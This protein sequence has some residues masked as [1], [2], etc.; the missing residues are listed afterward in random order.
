M[1]QIYL[2]CMCI[3]LMAA[4]MPVHT[5]DQ[6]DIEVYGGLYDYWMDATSIAVSEDVGYVTTHNGLAGVEFDRAQATLLGVNR[7]VWVTHLFINEDNIFALDPTS[8]M[9][10]LDRE[11]LEI[12]S[13]I[14]T[15]S[16]NQDIIVNRDIAYIANHMNG[17]ELIDISDPANPEMIA[18]LDLPGAS[19]KLAYFESIIY[20]A[21]AEAGLRIVDVS[22]P[23][24]PV[25]VGSY[26]LDGR[27][28]DVNIYGQYVLIA[29]D[30]NGVG[31]LDISD[32]ENV[33][34]IS[35]YQSEGEEPL[36]RIREGGDFVYA[37]HGENNIEILSVSDENEIS[38]TNLF[39]IDGWVVTNIVHDATNLYV[40]LSLPDVYGGR[41]ARIDMENPENVVVTSA[42]Q[43]VGEAQDVTIIGD[44]GFLKDANRHEDS[45]YRIFDVTN[46]ENPVHVS[47][48]AAIGGSDID[49]IDDYLFIASDAVTIY[50]LRNIDE[51]RQ[52]EAY[53]EGIFDIVTWDDVL[54]AVVQDEGIQI[55]NPD[56]P[57]NIEVIGQIDD[58]ATHIGADENLL[59]ALGDGLRIYDV[60]NPAETA[61]LNTVDNLNGDEIVIQGNL[62]FLIT[63]DADAGDGFQIVDY[64]DPENPVVYELFEPENSLVD[65]DV[66][67]TFAYLTC[68]GARLEVIDITNPAEPAVAGFYD[69][70]FGEMYGLEANGI[71]TY[72]AE[73]DRIVVYGCH[74]AMG[75]NLPPE[76]EEIPEDIIVSESEI[77]EFR[78][79]ASDVDE[80]ELTITMDLDDFPEGPVFTDNGDGTAEFR[81]QTGF[82]DAGGFQGDVTVS[83]GGNEISSRVG[84]I[85]RNFNRPPVIA[86]RIPD[87]VVDEDIGEFEIALLDTIFNDPDGD[88]MTY[89]VQSDVRELN[90]TIVNR[91]TLKMRPELNFNFPEGTDV[92]Y[93]ATDVNNEVF[94]SSF[95]VVVE[96]VNDPPRLFTLL[97][98]RPG[99]VL[100]TF[101]ANFQW[102]PTTDEEG[103][104][105]RYSM[106]MNIRHGDIDS[107]FSWSAGTANNML[108]TQLDTI[109][110][111]LGIDTVVTANWWAVATDSVLYT[112]S[113][114]RWHMILPSPLHIGEPDDVVPTEL[115]L[116]QPFPNPFNSRT[117]IRFALPTPGFVDMDVFDS[118]GRY[119][120]MLLKDHYYPNGWQRVTWNGVGA[121]AGTYLI[122]LRMD[123]KVLSQTVR[124]IK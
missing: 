9:T 22:N 93:T 103:D 48:F 34:E 39:M 78:V 18:R 71:Y 104:T 54:Y 44:Y 77:A 36:R 119:V 86:N 101:A 21:A 23:Q 42:Y 109:L 25:E 55:L 122:R 70:D 120:S 83:D 115:T 74:A 89:R 51:P 2:S 62:I 118:N 66:Q 100:N 82:E 112:E 50:N 117:T 85:I 20:V 88:N 52:V 102:N 63:Y 46:P 41:V 76:W 87:I 38:L 81:W 111:G 7:E 67:G 65:L 14:E 29:N 97:N 24:E 31:I 92:Q 91:R 26:E 16:P 98:P 40:S 59:Y 57:D 124:L 11:N 43:S 108:L 80:Q 123:D 110:T 75:V 60:S 107:T 90:V 19:L 33:E 84:V 56:D 79:V 121:P 49:Q 17:L 35:S 32:P 113:A 27:T 47:S 3:F 95:N 4:Y 30:E 96:A 37:L 106:F 45:G 6:S 114:Q 28:V 5:Q 64:A 105:V 8:G 15:Q 1:K 58:A 69:N 68:E 61:L 72:V 53:G 94:S 116:T 10:I 13:N 12:I 73:R 99:T